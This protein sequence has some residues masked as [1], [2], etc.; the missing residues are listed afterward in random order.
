MQPFAQ[1]EAW[2]QAASHVNVFKIYPQW[3]SQASDADL[4]IQFADLHRRGIAL[5][6]EWGMLT[7][8]DTCGRGIEGFGGQFPLDT[9]RRIQRLGVHLRYIAID[10]PI[11]YGTLYK[12]ANACRWTVD[13]MAQNAAANITA[14]HAEFPGIAVG[15][16]EPLPVDETDKNWL[17]QYARGIDA[18]QK[19]TGAPLAFMHSDIAWFSSQWPAAMSA[20]RQVVQTRGILFGVIYNGDES[21]Q[22]DA[23][24]I[25]AA[26]AP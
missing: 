18:L 12:S 11:F 6:L 13:Q 26:E 20:M 3:I 25:D 17:D 5:A 1:D 10:E 23:A 22:S 15:D 9:V 4:K 21:E 8:N 24:W 16:I 2:S 19:A 14:L 7:P